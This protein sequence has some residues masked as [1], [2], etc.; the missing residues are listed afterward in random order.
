MRMLPNEFVL[1]AAT[2]SASS[3]PGITYVGA[4]ILL[5]M[6]PILLAWWAGLAVFGAATMSIRRI[7]SLAAKGR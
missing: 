4:P 2:A 7:G 1:P 6:T 5:A 3:A